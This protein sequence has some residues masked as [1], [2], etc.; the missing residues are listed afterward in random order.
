MLCIELDLISDQMIP[1]HSISAEPSI[2]RRAWWN[3]SISIK[4]TNECEKDI[5]DNRSQSTGCNN[6]KGYVAIKSILYSLPGLC[7][8][9]YLIRIY[10]KIPIH[11]IA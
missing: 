2:Q 7:M 6:G 10:L 8:I 3:R 4:H 1:L 9:I 5:E 11:L